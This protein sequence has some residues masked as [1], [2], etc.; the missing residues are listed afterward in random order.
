MKSLALLLVA[1][2]L[3]LAA[4]DP[5]SFQQP[6]EFASED[7]GEL[8]VEDGKARTVFTSNGNYFI[9]LN[10]TYLLLY[11]ALFGIGLLA[12]LAL[13]SLFSPAEETG[14]GYSHQS[15]GGGYGGGSAHG[16]SYYRQRRS[17]DSG[18]GESVEKRVHF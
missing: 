16:H 5:L 12:A 3:G 7:G 15:G 1:A 2:S 18:E 8:V 13:A 10:T 6:A 14:Y 17:A 11:A 9:A 4:A